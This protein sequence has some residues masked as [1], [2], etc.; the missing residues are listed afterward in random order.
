MEVV[1]FVSSINAL[2]GTANTVMK[3]L[4]SVR[5]A[6][7]EQESFENEV[8]TT[9]S[10]LTSL[11]CRLTVVMKYRDSK[12]GTAWYRS[13]STQVITQGAIEELDK[14]LNVVKEKIQQEDP[15]RAKMFNKMGWYFRKD[16]CMDA[17]E[18][19]HR[20]KSDLIAALSSDTLTIAEQIADGIDEVKEGLREIHT[21]LQGVRED[22][23]DLA[24]TVSHTAMFKWLGAPEVQHKHDKLRRQH[25]EATG[26]WFLE[27]DYFREW[28]EDARKLLWVTGIRRSS[29]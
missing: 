14:S 9:Q 16:T 5:H 20:I 3:Y 28:K 29:S 1:G 6:L 11:F 8:K 13:I 18:R 4:Q 23:G 27:T 26:S 24:S 22:V 15:K 25:Q 7:E 21:T 10:L 2:I 12:S 17:V 19:M